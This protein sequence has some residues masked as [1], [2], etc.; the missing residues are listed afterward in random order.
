MGCIPV[1][2]QGI[3]DDESWVDFLTCII[4]IVMPDAEA[5]RY[6]CPLSRPYRAC[7]VTGGG[8]GDHQRDRLMG[9]L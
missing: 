1:G 2:L 8:M 5:L 9:G 6:D 4:S 7:G 3:G